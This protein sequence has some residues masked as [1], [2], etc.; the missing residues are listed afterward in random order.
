LEYNVCGRWAAVTP[1]SAKA[2]SS[3][4]RGAVRRGNTPDDPTPQAKDI[5]CGEKVIK[6][7]RSFAGS[8][9]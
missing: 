3:P 1:Q 7:K 5:V 9:F 6:R 8:T 2:D 4:K